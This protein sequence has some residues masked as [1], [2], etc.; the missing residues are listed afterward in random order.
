MGPIIGAAFGC[1]WSGV[2]ADRLT[3]ML[4][5]RNNGVREPEQR[6]WP[7]A[8]SAILSCAGLIIWGVGAQHNVSWPGLAIGLG[9]LTFS[10][11][12]GGSIALSYNVDCF[13]DISG[14]ST[15]SVIIIRNTL[16]FAVSYGITPWY[17]NMGLQDCFIMAGFL[18]LGCTSTF[19]FMFWKGK[20]LRRRS[21]PRYWHL[22]QKGIKVA[23]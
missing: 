4:A 13:K 19:L 15:T 22:A 16:G 7:L 20:S 17:T 18:S 6:L 11:I 23:H 2:V 1:I 12:T 3:L 14:M 5:R 10:V 21:A 9:V 8:L